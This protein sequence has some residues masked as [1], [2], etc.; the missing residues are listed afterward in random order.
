MKVNAEMIPC[1]VRGVLKPIGISKPVH[2]GG[3]GKFIIIIHPF[4]LK[5]IIPDATG[6]FKSSLLYKFLFNLCRII[7]HHF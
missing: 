4:F 3:D 7:R 5:I 2:K 6:N 1:P